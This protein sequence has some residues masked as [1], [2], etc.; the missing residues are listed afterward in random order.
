[1]ST[2]TPPAFQVGQAVRVQRDERLFPSK[3]TWPRYRSQ[4]GFVVMINSSEDTEP[5]EY[6]VVLTTT[7]PPWRREKNRQGEVQYDS[8]AVKWFAGHELV[9]R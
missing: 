4:P 3:G 9:A 6:G 8:D 2:L 7:R 1:M 5:P